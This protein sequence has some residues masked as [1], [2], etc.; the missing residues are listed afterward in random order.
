MPDDYEEYAELYT[1]MCEN[2][3]CEEYAEEREMSA[4]A[5]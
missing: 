3:S 5:L 1:Q 2:I 4:Y